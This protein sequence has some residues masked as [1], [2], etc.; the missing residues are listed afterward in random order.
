MIFFYFEDGTVSL[1]DVCG[2][3]FALLPRRA[4]SSHRANQPTLFTQ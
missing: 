4:H 2:F 1:I 3:D